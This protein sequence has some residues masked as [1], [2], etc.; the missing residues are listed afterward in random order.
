MNG[1]QTVILSSP[2]KMILE[3]TQ[4]GVELAL[5]FHVCKGFSVQSK[6]LAQWY[7]CHSALREMR[8]PSSSLPKSGALSLTGAETHI[9]TK[10][11]IGYI[12]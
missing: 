3:R 12:A 2:R 6:I 8:W 10:I 7:H 9:T 11:T 5:F 1:R 4:P